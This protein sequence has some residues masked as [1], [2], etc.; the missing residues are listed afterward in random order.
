MNQGTLYTISAASGTGKSTLVTAL[1]N[2]IDNLK[3]SVS[4]TTRIARTGE[5]EGVHYHFVSKTEFQQILEADVFVEYAT[6]FDNNYGTSKQWL[7][8]QLNEGIDVILEIDWQGAQKVRQFQPN[9]VSIFVLPP[10]FEI[11][12]TRLRDRKTDSE[13]VI[14]NRLRGAR[15]DISHYIEYDYIVL[16]DD[17]SQAL[18]DLRSIIHS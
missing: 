8:E 14:L 17:F 10:S 9:L 12:E 4:H 16:N 13:E 6:V 3:L 2:S 1:I 15:E 7:S 11:L 5:I 18:E